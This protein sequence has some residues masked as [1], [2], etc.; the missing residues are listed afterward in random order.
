VLANKRLLITG[1]VNSESIAYATAERAQLQGAEVILTAFPRDRELTEQAAAVLPAPAEIIDA[2]LTSRDDLERLT[3]HLRDTVGTIDGA[4]HAIA[5]APK[6]ALAGDF[7][8][9]S[10]EGVNL[11]FQTSAFSY[12]SLGRILRDL[13]PQDG[14][15]LVGLDFDAGGAWPVYNW[16]GVCKSALESV[17]RY[18]ARDLGPLNIRTNLVA[19][20]P[21]HTRAA[22]GI[23]DFD[24]LL[25][26]WEQGAPLVWSPQDPTPV[27]DAACFLLSE[28]ARAITGEVLHVD[29]GYHAMASSLRT[30]TT[31]NDQLQMRASA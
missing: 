16:M 22:G 10:P 19:A 23:P 30:S 18:L 9:A 1:I 26:A 8:A 28:S 13:A 5:F 4:L 25:Q 6:D 21:L 14:G 27:A 24:K 12:A 11:A 3:R 31:N 20:G 17:N 2:D 29:G 7:L 15:A